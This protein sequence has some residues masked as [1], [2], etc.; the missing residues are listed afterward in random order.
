MARTGRT[1]DGFRHGGR[2]TPLD[3]LTRTQREKVDADLG[4]LVER[5]ADVAALTDVRRTA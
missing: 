2:W 1:L 3:R 4:A 5:L